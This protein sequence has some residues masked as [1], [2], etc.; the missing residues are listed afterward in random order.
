MI[1]AKL[2]KE[3]NQ[4]N[5]K[6]DVSLNIKKGELVTLYGESG[7]GKTSLLRMIA[8]L[9]NPEE[10][11][12]KVG[13]QIWLDSKKNI[14]L[15]P[16]HRKIGFVFQD[17]ALFPN[18]TVK[19]NLAYSGADSN[20]LHELS[21]LMGIHGLLHRKPDTLSGGEKQRTALARTLLSDPEVLLLDEPL[22]ALDTSMRK[23]LQD[24]I[25]KIHQE[26]QLTTLLVSHDL[27]EIFRLSN[28]VLKMENGKIIAE[29]S[30]MDLFT[31]RKISGKFQFIGEI[32]AIEKE[33]VVN[34]ITLLIGNHPVKVITETSNEEGL[35]IGDKVLV[36]SKAFNPILR[37]IH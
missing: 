1:R 4:G 7:A 35:Q 16:Q 20:R 14:Y 19:Q 36:A 10:G 13:E 17:Y 31:D 12:I 32:V 23:Q 2:K 21:E 8:G 34:V 25:L 27:G 5:L 24:L 28:H 15:K 33:D 11:Q 30:P 3:L 18:M 9:M 22:S 29:G 6:I 26:F 37:K